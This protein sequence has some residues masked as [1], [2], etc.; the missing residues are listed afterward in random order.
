MNV[1]LDH[2]VVNVIDSLADILVIPCVDEHALGDI[3][4]R[5]FVK[6]AEQ[7]IPRIPE[8][9]IANGRSIDLANVITKGLG[10]LKGVGHGHMLCVVL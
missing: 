4:D 6:I 1:R 9:L 7:V 5:R 8:D 3:S 10:S 2:P